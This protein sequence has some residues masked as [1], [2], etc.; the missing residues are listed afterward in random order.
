MSIVISIFHVEI[1]LLKKIIKKKKKTTKL[2][3]T[4]IFFPFFFN[5]QLFVALSWNFRSYYNNSC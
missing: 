3:A 4:L 2:K 1:I 5:P